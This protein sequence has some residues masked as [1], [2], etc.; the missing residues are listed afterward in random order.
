MECHP[1]EGHEAGR[2]NE[3]FAILLGGA[4]QPGVICVQDAWDADSINWRDC[5]DV[6]M[7]FGMLKGIHICR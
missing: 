4:C 2:R 7:G 5:N 6:S 3:Q 1:L